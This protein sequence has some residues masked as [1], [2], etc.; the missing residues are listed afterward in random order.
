MARRTPSTRARRPDSTISRGAGALA[1]RKR[2]VF[3]APSTNASR[4][5]CSRAVCGLPSASGDPGPLSQPATAAAPPPNSSDLGTEPA[6]NATSPSSAPAAR[7]PSGP[8]EPPTPSTIRPA[9]TATAAVNAPPSSSSTSDTLDRGDPSLRAWS[10]TAS[11]TAHTFSAVPISTRFTLRCAGTVGRCTTPGV[12][13][14]GR[15]VR[16]R[17]RTRLR[18]PPLP[19]VSPGA[20]RKARRSASSVMPWTR[21]IGNPYPDGPTTRS[22]GPAASSSATKRAGSASAS[23]VGQERSRNRRPSSSPQRSMLTVPGSM[24]MTR[25][26]GSR[27]GRHQLPRD[28]GDGL[29]VQHE[30]VALEQACD[31]RLVQLRLEVSDAKSTEDRDAFLHD[32]RVVHFDTL[33]TERRNRVQVHGYLERLHR[34]PAGLRHHLNSRGSSVEEDVH[35]IE[36]ARQLCGIRQRRALDLDPEASVD[37]L[38]RLLTLLRLPGGDGDARAGLGE[39]SGCPLADRARAS[40]DH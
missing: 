30:V 16:A 3:T 29:G 28:V 40:Q 10:D 35:P 14:T 33:D 9:A 12:S 24:P 11:A 23:A 26:I 31:A 27:L 6:R 37:E 34:G 5:V 18:S 13:T 21:V 39:E 19:P 7:N 4:A 22:S 8:A 15:A 2:T 17:A 25:G 1:C 36:H 32:A 38:A 20:A